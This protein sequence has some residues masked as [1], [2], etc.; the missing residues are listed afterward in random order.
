MDYFEVVAQQVA[1]KDHDFYGKDSENQIVDSQAFAFTASG[2]L[3]GHYDIQLI[4]HFNQ[5]NAI[6]AGLACLRL[7]DTLADIR[8]GIAQTSVPGR[9]EVLTQQNGAKVFVDYAHNGDSL[10]KLL[11]VVAEHQKGQNILI[12]GS[13]GNKAESRRA[14]FGR[15]IQNRPDLQ[16]ILTADD[17]NREDPQKIA[18]E[19]ASYVDRPLTIMVDREEAIQKALSLTSTA[20]DAVI[21]AGKGADAYQIVNDEKVAYPGDRQ[22]ASLYL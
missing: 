11:S 1:Q 19:I 9:M 16:V 3:A 5:E 14:D 20:A 8:T 6:A 18:E 17:P 15:V 12:L 2:K 22:V 7:G 10:E 13:T 21:I 4:G